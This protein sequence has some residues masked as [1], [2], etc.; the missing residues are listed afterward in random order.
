VLQ[1]NIVHQIKDFFRHFLK[2]AVAGMPLAGG[3]ANNVQ[4]AV[5][6][7]CKTRLDGLATSLHWSSLQ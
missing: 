3:R 2:A 6:I 1:K 4:E 7:P 5:E